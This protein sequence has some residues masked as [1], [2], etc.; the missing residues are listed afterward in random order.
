MMTTLLISIITLIKALYFV[1]EDKQVP[2]YKSRYT[3][4]SVTFTTT[5]SYPTKWGQLQTKP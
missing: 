1:K 3:L 2:Q 4:K 5:K